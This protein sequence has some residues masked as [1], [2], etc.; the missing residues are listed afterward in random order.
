VQ[1]TTID[2]G[3]EGIN[4]GK[5]QALG[6]LC[7]K[8][9]TMTS[10]SNRNDAY[11]DALD[12]HLQGITPTELQERA[13]RRFRERSLD[14]IRESAE[15][16]NA[17][18]AFRDAL[19]EARPLAPLDARQKEAVARYVDARASAVARR[20][21]KLIS[22][23]QQQVMDETADIEIVFD[24]YPASLDS[25]NASFK[26][27]VPP[28]AARSVVMEGKTSGT[29]IQMATVDR[30]AGSINTVAAINQDGGSLYTEACLWIRF[31]RIHDS[32]DKLGLLIPSDGYGQIRPFFKYSFEYSAEAHLAYALTQGWVGI[33]VQSTNWFGQ[34]DRVDLDW[35]Q[36]L[37]RSRLHHTFGDFSWGEHSHSPSSPDS[38][39]GVA[40]VWDYECPVFKI[41]T[42]RIYS[43]ILWVGTNTSAEGAT[44]TAASIAHSV[45]AASIPFVAVWQTK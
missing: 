38:D 3:D 39:G 15:D 5:V 37:W 24:I 43:A 40:F 19:N 21:E 32:I 31:G 2:A 27:H 34:D 42:S 20:S 11:Y 16:W 45:L 9:Q 22:S 6:G 28:Y 1:E 25:S 8:W 14:F 7:R 12:S 35:R 29:Q 36:P 33:W 17:R 4:Y 10:Q 26:L 30:R 18:I 44:L 41:E 23:L 13:E